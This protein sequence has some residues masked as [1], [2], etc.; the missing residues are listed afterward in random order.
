MGDPKIM[1]KS[2]WCTP[3][4]EYL[5]RPIPMKQIPTAPA[6]VFLTRGM[7]YVAMIMENPTSS[8]NIESTGV[9]NI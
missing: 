7:K 4:Y 6:A 8:S 5:S 9:V 2:R 1:G 3:T